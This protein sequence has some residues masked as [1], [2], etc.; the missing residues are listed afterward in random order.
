TMV[1]KDPTEGLTKH[2]D[3]SKKVDK[4]MAGHYVPAENEV[5]HG[6]YRITGKKLGMGT[7]GQVLEAYDETSSQGVAVKIIKNHSH[8]SVQ[9]QTEI[10]ILQYMHTSTHGDRCHIVRMVD[11]FTH[12][13]HECLV[14]PL[15]SYNLYELLRS[16]QFKG[17]GLKLIRKFAKQIVESLEFLA[18][19]N[20][21]HCDLKPENIVIARPNRSNIKI[22]DFGSSCLSDKRVHTYIQSRF[23]RAPEI[24]LGMKYTTAIDMWSVGCILV[25]L[26]TGS[27]LFA[28][29]DLPDQ[30]RKIVQVLGMV[31]GHV[32]EQANPSVRCEYFAREQ[33]HPGCTPTRNYTLRKK[34]PANDAPMSLESICTLGGRRLNKE[35]DHSSDDYAQFVD[36]VTRMLEIEY[37]CDIA[38]FPARR[39][40]PAM[41]LRHPFFQDRPL[42]H[43]RGGGDKKRATK[44]ADVS[45]TDDIHPTTTTEDDPCQEYTHRAKQRKLLVP[46]P[47][48]DG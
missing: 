41:A 13:G 3:T 33:Q 9:A 14:F 36:L 31:P 8:F 38:Y 11:H 2:V 32:V 30:L 43:T 10:K 46:P 37:V 24:L 5:L 28:G 26:H 16:S 47:H 4:I 20:V 7:F 6:R 29:Q 19:I 42:P 48:R 17:V 12:K 45:M 22:I 35:P 27:P 39:I 18:S 1:S 44:P 34:C 40:P 25:E 21:I 15:C 23:Y